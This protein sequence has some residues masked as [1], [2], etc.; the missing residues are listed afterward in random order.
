MAR[1]KLHL[2]DLELMEPN[3]YDFFRNA[4]F[5]KQNYS[6]QEFSAFLRLEPYTVE[7]EIILFRLMLKFIDTEDYMYCAKIR[8]WINKH[9]K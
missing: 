7:L 8:D 6:Y 2:K 4:N 3:N 1:S 5:I 9:T